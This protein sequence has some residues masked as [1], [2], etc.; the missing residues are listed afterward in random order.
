[1]PVIRVT[2]TPLT[3]SPVIKVSGKVYKT[4]KSN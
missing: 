1:M 4:Q 3:I 2:P